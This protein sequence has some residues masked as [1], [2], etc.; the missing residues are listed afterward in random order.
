MSLI[1]FS[2][3]VVCIMGLPF[4]VLGMEEAV[5]RVRGAAQNGT[6][7]FVSTPNL[8]FAVAARHDEDFRRS[9]ICSQLSLADG[10]P[11]VWISR[12][13]GLPIRERVSG[14]GL[15]EA[16]LRAPGEPLKVFFFG[17][18]DGVAELAGGRLN[19][20]AGGLRC[21]GFESPGFVSI[22]EMSS[23]DC[24]ERINRAAPDFIVVSLGAK[25]GQAWIE[26]NRARLNAPVISHLGAVVNFA[27]QTIRRAPVW[28]QRLGLEWLWRIKEEPG[29]WRRYAGD[30]KALARYFVSGVLP[31][32]TEYVW[33]LHGPAVSLTFDISRQ[34]PVTVLRLAGDCVGGQVAVVRQALE[35]VVAGMGCP[36]D[37]RIDLAAVRRVDA[38]ALGTLMLFSAFQREAQRQLEIV[39]A[40][41][42][43]RRHFQLCG[44]DFLLNGGGTKAAEVVAFGRDFGR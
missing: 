6:P 15:F 28:V 41:V 9:V 27:A 11:I 19:A 21:V 10:M 26:R 4:D 36:T 22:D 40:S 1:D 24:I 2:R 35:G 31:L 5:H 42:P 12:L 32:W 34:G 13:L 37:V 23:D 33:R 38:T 30:G 16:L 43:V 25:K 7:Y 3:N 39:G 17:G 44:A 8:N 29:L 18:A 20:Q 14:A